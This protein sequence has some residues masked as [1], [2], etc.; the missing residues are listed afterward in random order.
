MADV[1]IF[2]DLVVA[3]EEDAKARAIV[4]EIVTGAI[5]DAR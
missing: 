2:D 1:I 3:V 4:N 5:A